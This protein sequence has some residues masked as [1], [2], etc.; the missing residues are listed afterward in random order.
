M[1]AYRTPGVYLERPA[2]RPALGLPRTDVAGFVGVARRGPLHRPVRLESRNELLA[3]FG[4]PTAQGYL[5]CAVEGFFANGGQTCW[6]VRAADPEK[7]WPASVEIADDAGSPALRL[8]ASSPGVWGRKLTATVVRGGRGRFTLLLRL[9]DGPPELWRDL[10]PA[11]LEALSELNAGSRLVAASLPAGASGAPPR[12]GRYRLAGG[13]DGLATLRAEHL[14]EGLAAL[15]AVDEVAIVALPDAMPVPRVQPRAKRQPPC[16]DVP[17]D[18]PVQAEEPEESLEFP[19]A[20]DEAGISRVQN[21]LIAHCERL[22]DR[23]A[24]LDVPPSAV[25]P[26]DALAWRRDMDSSYAALYYPW[27]RVPD[28]LE[29]EGLLRAV[30]PSGH[31]AGIWA[32]SDRRVGV[33]KPPANEALEGVEDVLFRLGDEDHG[34]LNCAGV[35]AIRPYDG[36]G[37]RVAGARTVS[38]DP[39]L[40]YVNVR[41]LLLMIA[42]AVDEGTQWTVFEPHDL[43]LRREIDRV[44]RSFLDGLFRRG[45]LDG[46]KAEEAYSVRCD[47]TTNPPAEAEAGR[48]IC[49]IGVQP[50]W[51]AEFV[52]VRLAKSVSGVELLETQD[53]REAGRG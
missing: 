31:V 1:L 36:R 44:V 15:E 48:L 26:R 33:H 28:P 18:G 3:T 38:S 22:R 39:L 37:I 43:R 41:R 30:P 32:R 14:I 13:A 42:E 40:R 6:V 17:C 20:P 49:Q 5:A 19:P 45:V 52:I 51:P 24:V 7:A 16:C 10:P 25:T 11:G 47:E 4:G 9:G 2:S 50:P 34:D 46:A 21:A 12:A 29:L 23:V 35:N 53:G 8:T 27:L